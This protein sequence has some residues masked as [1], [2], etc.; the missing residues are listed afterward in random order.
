MPAVACLAKGPCYCLRMNGETGKSETGRCCAGWLNQS[1]SVPP[2]C[3]CAT[4]SPNYVRFVYN[5]SSGEAP[6]VTHAGNKVIEELFTAYFA[7]HGLE[8]VLDPFDGRS[9]YEGF[10]EANVPGADGCRCVV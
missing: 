7:D 9:D 2:S 4:G 1:L 5:A 3:T 8:C 10:I 6:P